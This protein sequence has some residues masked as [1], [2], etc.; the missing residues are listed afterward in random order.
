MRAPWGSSKKVKIKKLHSERRN[1]HCWSGQFSS[2][3]TLLSS[4]NSRYPEPALPVRKSWLALPMSA[5]KNCSQFKMCQGLTTPPFLVWFLSLFSFESRAIPEFTKKIKTW[6]NLRI[7][8]NVLAINDLLPSHINQCTVH[9]GPF[10]NHSPMQMRTSLA[11]LHLSNII[12]ALLA[13]ICI[14]LETKMGEFRPCFLQ[15]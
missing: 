10:S 9:R 15:L 4:F 3:F 12:K 5:W 1:E 7:E 2:N 6:N 14:L 8:S 11:F 13:W